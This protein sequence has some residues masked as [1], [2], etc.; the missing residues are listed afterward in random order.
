VKNCLKISLALAVWQICFFPVQS[1]AAPTRPTPPTHPTHTTPTAAKD[2]VGP[3]VMLKFPKEAPVGK[4]VRLQ[5]GGEH[6]IFLESPYCLAQGDVSVGYDDVF[7][8]Q[9]NNQGAQDLSFFNSLPPRTVAGLEIERFVMT[10]ANF[11][12]LTALEHL[13]KLSVK[14]VDVGDKSLLR[15][16]A[17]K[18]LEDLRLNG[19]LITGRGLSALKD[20][21]TLTVLALDNNNLDDASIANLSGLTNLVNLRLEATR[22]G[23]TGVAYLK[24][25][26]LL[27]KLV[28]RRNSKITDASIPVFIGLTKLKK[29]DLTDCKIS[30]AGLMRLKKMPRLKHLQIAFKDY[31]SGQL[32][33]LRHVLAPQC[34]LVDGRDMEKPMVIFS[35]L[36]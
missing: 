17:C 14:E 36:R 20:L 27:R 10:D 9:V 33:R 18:S 7:L 28:L 1:L 12:R 24:D 26:K 25:L 30:A 34:K 13:R 8:L 23:D 6:D 4:L 32:D 31:D 19:T 3:R 16:K 2:N 29:L 21:R 5:D 22:I 15:L 35:P 11:A